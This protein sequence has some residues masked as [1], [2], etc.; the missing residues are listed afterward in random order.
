MQTELAEPIE[1]VLKR[2]LNVKAEAAEKYLYLSFLTTLSVSRFISLKLAKRHFSYSLRK[3]M[4][5]RLI[6]IVNV[7]INGFSLSLSLCASLH[8][9]K[10][11]LKLFAYK[12]LTKLYTFSTQVKYFT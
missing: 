8:H 7:L 11:Y 12:I 2:K 6:A 10:L 1:K 3:I 4:L 9:A 5:D